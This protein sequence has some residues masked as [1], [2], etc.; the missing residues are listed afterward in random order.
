LS[1]LD[2]VV[3]LT[4][5]LLYLAEKYPVSIERNSVVK[6]VLMYVAETWSLYEVDRRRIN[7]TEMDALRRSAKISKLD[8]VKVK[9]KQYRYRP[10]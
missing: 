3:S 2:R 1:A 4:F 10:G 9:V 6:H 7:A 8:K 5:W